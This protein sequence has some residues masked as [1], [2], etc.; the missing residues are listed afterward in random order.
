[1][2]SVVES[3]EINK[4]T[5]PYVVEELTL[6]QG[7]FRNVT[8]V[9]D[10]DSNSTIFEIPSSTIDKNILKVFVLKSNAD[11]TGFDTIWQE[12]TNYI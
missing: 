9:Y 6:R 4:N 2:F 8:F 1:M 5:T 3:Q 12:N 11:R 10:P 7:R